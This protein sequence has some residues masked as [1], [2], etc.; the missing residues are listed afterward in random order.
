MPQIEREG[1]DPTDHLASKDEHGR[2]ALHRAAGIGDVEAVHD[3]LT[4]GADPCILDSRMGAAPLH[5][6]AQGGSVE[7]AQLLIE[8]GAFI[9]LQ[10]P[11]HGITPLM[12]AVWH[13]K[14]A[15]VTFLLEQPTINVQI[16]SNFGMTAADLIG[17]GAKD[18]DS[19]AA[20]QNNELEKLFAEQ[21]QRQTQR[22]QEQ[23]LFSTLV[24]PDLSVEQKIEQSRV[25]LDA[26]AAVNT[27]SPVTS[28]DNDGHTPLLV[29]TRDGLVDAVELF[30][31]AGADQTLAD[32]YMRAIPAHKAAYMGH[33]EVLQVLS[34]FPGFSA[35]LNQQGPFNGYTPLHDAVWHGHT[36]AAQVL[37]EA[38][39]QIDLVGYDGKTPLALAIEYH[40]EDIADL[41]RKKQHN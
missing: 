17:F 32:H 37:L 36:E 25:L 28:S 26:G 6:A 21:Q 19:F 20:Q 24:N 39:A 29:A 22:Y 34:R 2:T 16:R 30:L 14:I 12:T 18:D 15:F 4:R 38:G 33:T 7:V 35:V 40:Y 3:L 10:A 5:H 41:I 23:S 13:R 31:E 27:A 9:N 1:V 11:T 8:H